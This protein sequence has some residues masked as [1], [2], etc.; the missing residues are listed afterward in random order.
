MTPIAVRLADETVA[1]IDALVA[2]GWYPT[3]SACIKDALDQLLSALERR[4]VDEAM[5]E[6]YRRVPQTADELALADASAKAIDEALGA[7]EW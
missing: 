7:D 2:A 6:G 1:E 4:R 5:V 3:R